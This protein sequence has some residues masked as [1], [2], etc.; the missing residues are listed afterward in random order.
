MQISLEGKVALITGGGAGIGKATVEAFAAIGA[1][2]AIAEI[3]ADKCAALAQ[4]FPDA[5]VEPCDVRD[6]AAV[7]ALL[8]KVADRFGRLDVLVNNVGHHLSIRCDFEHSTEDQWQAMYDIN[9]RQMMIVTR[10]AIPLMKAGGRGGSIINVS[11]V[12]G[13]RGFPYN[14]VYTTFKH[15][16]TGFTR[17]LA[18]ELSTHAIRVNLIA[19]ET[20]DSEQVPLDKILASPEMRAQADGTIPLGRF[21]TPQDHAN[22]AVYLATDLS[23]WV[24][25]HSL[26]VD[27]GAMAAGV[28]QRTPDGQWTNMP[29]VSGR[30]TAGV[31]GAKQRS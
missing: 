23:S 1:Q 13:F 27:G 4:Q 25:G 30:C 15:A 17:G 21:G 18:V 7:E 6:V 9:L 3:D 2:L 31:T 8:D 24:T 29:I 12:E 28:F 20:T 11:S 5:L 16:V 10:A 26:F 22:A 19:P 14:I